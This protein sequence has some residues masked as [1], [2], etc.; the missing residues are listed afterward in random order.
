MR[1]TL[2]SEWDR[3]LIYSLFF[4]FGVRSIFK[5]L[6]VFSDVV[7]VYYSLLL[8]LEFILAGLILI[9]G[10]FR[11]SRGL[12]RAGYVV[13][14]LGL[15]TVGALIAV[16]AQSTI[17]WLITA[18]AVEMLVSLRRLKERSLQQQLIDLVDAAKGESQE[19]DKR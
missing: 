13:S 17:T 7:P 14:F 15:L 5:P 4:G 18:F 11:H 12:L 3:L 16:V 19:R 9:A 8:S 2:K 6:Q 1:N 10:T